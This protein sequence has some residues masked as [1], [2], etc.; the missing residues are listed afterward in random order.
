MNRTV[1]KKTMY[2]FAIPAL[3]F[4]LIFW[5]FPILKLFQYSV[6]DY[7]GFSPDFNYIGLDNFKDLFASGTLGTSLWHTILYTVI[8][9]ALGNLIGLALALMLNMNIRGKGFYRSISYIPTLFSAIVVGFIWS[10]V[11]MPDSGMITT[12]LSKIGVNTENINFLGNY[13]TALYS[14]I[15]VEI[16]KN[17][18]TTMIIF[19]AGLQTVPKDL[20]EAGEIDGCGPWRLLRNIKLPLLATS[21]TINIT[22][23]LIN[24]LKAFDFP[25]IMTSGG[26]G[27]STNTLIFSIY[28]MAF[29]E[30]MFGK[31]SALGILSF[32][33]IMVITGI[34]VLN[35]NKREVSA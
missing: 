8:S 2:F 26:P 18:G 31:A 33:F 16:W 15:F 30:Q 21:V 25:F 20:L 7:N 29:T 24:G 11:Y 12:L 32:L 19:L 27:T 4:Y 6:T 34:F 5:I 1:M 28:K 10:Y 3:V 23:S 35:M 14:I 22:L 9:V 13:S 17:I